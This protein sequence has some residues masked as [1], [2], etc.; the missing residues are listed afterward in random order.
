MAEPEV[1][2]VSLVRMRNPDTKVDLQRWRGGCSGQRG[3]LTPRPPS[4][5]APPKPCNGSRVM[6]APAGGGERGDLEGGGR[7]FQKCAREKGGPGFR[8]GKSRIVAVP[9]KISLWK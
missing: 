2:K 5:S 1:P 9:R 4:D 3:A 6:E 8:Q 7:Q